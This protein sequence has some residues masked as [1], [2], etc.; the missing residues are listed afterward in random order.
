VHAQVPR[1]GSWGCPGHAEGPTAWDS[2]PLSRFAEA[3]SAKSRTWAWGNRVGGPVGH[4][5]GVGRARVRVPT[6]L[7]IAS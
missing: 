6:A 5:A 2:G 3:G 1:A 4:T 7:G